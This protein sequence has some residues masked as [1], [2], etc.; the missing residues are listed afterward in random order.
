M[1]ELGE[2]K[3]PDIEK[4]FVAGNRLFEDVTHPLHPRADLASMRGAI[5][6][7]LAG[8]GIISEVR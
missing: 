5:E 4:W 7:R 3:Q 8:G 1:G 2:G 6:C